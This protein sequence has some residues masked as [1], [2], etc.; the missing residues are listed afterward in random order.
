MKTLINIFI[1]F[2]L[3]STALF[4]QKN[5]TKDYKVDSFEKIELSGGYHVV[6]IQGNQHGVFVN[7]KQKEID[8]LKVY[9]KN[10]TL[11][12][13]NHKGKD[14]HNE[15]DKTSMVVQ[16]TFENLEE[17]ECA[18]AGNIES[19]GLLKFNSFELEYTGVG[20]LKLNMEAK[21]LDVEVTGVGS[22]E[23][24]GK[25]QTAKFEGTGVGSFDA[26][27]LLVRD[28]EGTWTGIGNMKVNAYNTCKISSAGIGSVKN[29]NDM[30]DN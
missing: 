1:L 8:E 23:F 16:I 26:R 30:K 10:N 29:Y 14:G 9:V 18:I 27:K 11:Y 5:Q 20:K 13:D 3:T 25:A 6:L 17:M 21:D 28:L 4:A 12:V 15:T 24:E 19:E 22:V 2:T 7:G